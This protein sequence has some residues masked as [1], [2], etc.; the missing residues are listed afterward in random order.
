ML[1]LNF[2]F[3]SPIDRKST[4]KYRNKLDNQAIENLIMRF[5]ES[6]LIKSHRHSKYLRIKFSLRMYD[7][8]TLNDSGIIFEIPKEIYSKGAKS[9]IVKVLEEHGYKVQ[10]S[11]IHERKLFV[12]FYSTGGRQ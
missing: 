2:I 4:D 5:T 10:T 8:D 6:C 1:L 12:V 7:V 11:A 9:L 3:K